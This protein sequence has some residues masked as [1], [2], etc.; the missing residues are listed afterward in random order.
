MKTECSQKKPGEADLCFTRL[1]H[2][3]AH[4]ANILPHPLSTIRCF[5]WRRARESRTRTLP[6]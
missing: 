1:S 5:T 2:A 3:M 6:G 4:F